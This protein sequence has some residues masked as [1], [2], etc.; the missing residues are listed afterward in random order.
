MKIKQSVSVLAFSI[1]LISLLMF[2]PY[3]GAAGPVTLMLGSGPSG[4][5]WYPLGA[6]IGEI[7]QK[8]IPGVTV[9]VQV[10]GG[11]LANVVGVNSGQYDIGLGFSHS[12]ADAINGIGEFKEK[13]PNIRGIVSINSTIFQCTV[14]ADSPIKEYENL[15]GKRLGPGLVG[16]AGEAT[17]RLVL[18]VHGLSYKDMARVDRLAYADTGN[19]MMDRHMDAFSILSYIPAPVIQELANSGGVRQLSLRPDR[20]SQIK[21]IN[22]GFAKYVIPANSYKGQTQEVVTVASKTIIMVTPKLPEDLAYKIAKALVANRGTLINVH[23]TMEEFTLQSAP[24]DLGIPLH[25][26]AEKFFKEKGVL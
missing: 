15:K 7:I 6:A 10:S 3:A 18:G 16:G 9:T 8:E 17:M 22:S 26:G 25:P 11:A 14:R 12:S 4:G 13:M 2:T 19:L 21:K 5:S 20:L 1:I 23:K 24:R